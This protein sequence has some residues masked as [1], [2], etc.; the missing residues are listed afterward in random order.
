[1]RLAYTVMQAYTP[2]QLENKIIK[3]EVEGNR[4]SDSVY[5]AKPP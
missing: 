4:L 5:T 1:M 3:R 2:N